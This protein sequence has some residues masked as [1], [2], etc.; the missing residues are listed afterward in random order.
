MLKESLS[1]RRRR[2]MVGIALAGLA[3]PATGRAAME[4]AVTVVVDMSDYGRKVPPPT[5]KRP[6][7]YLPAVGGYLERGAIIIG[8]PRP[9]P[10]A[11]V[12]EA[13]AVELAK[14]HYLVMDRQ[15]PPSIVLSIFWG[16]MNPQ[17]VLVPQI[18]P[19]TSP[20]VFSMGMF[21]RGG[22]AN[23]KEETSLVA[24]L[25]AA[26]MD[27]HWTAWTRM[28]QAV[29]DDRYFVM[30][31][32]WDYRYYQSTHKRRA[33]WQAKMSLP[34]YRTSLGEALPVLLAAGGPHFGR[35]TKMPALVRATLPAGTVKVGTPTVIGATPD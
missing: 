8:G 20:G 12:E 26:K 35:E 25:S 17:W 31:F 30:I 16:S 18:T 33:L 2:L 5:E 14:E 28:D 29:Y 15:H 32:A 23:R 19:S 10:E 6:D 1:D 13:V 27:G 24:G 21:S 22:I 4:T 3:W 7:Y 34:S 11:S 9:P